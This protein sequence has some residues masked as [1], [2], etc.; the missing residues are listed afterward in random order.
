[1]M[2]AA[3][4][5]G[6]DFD[7]AKFWLDLVQTVGL[8]AVAGVQFLISRDR[9]TRGAINK[10]D[11]QVELIDH[12]VIVLEQQI[13]TVPDDTTMSD[14]YKSINALNREMGSLKERLVATNSL[15][16]VLHKDRLGHTS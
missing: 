9:V 3:M 2:P 12:R 15:L 14:L 8:I 11:A 10:V 6:I 13:Q 16:D 4:A 5:A 7:A 1:M